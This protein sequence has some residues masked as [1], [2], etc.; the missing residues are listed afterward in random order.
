MKRGHGT[1]DICALRVDGCGE[2][3][4]EQR[5]EPSETCGARRSIHHDRPRP[6]HVDVPRRGSR[7]QEPDRPPGQIEQQK[8]VGELQR[9][10][11]RRCV[12]PSRQHEDLGYPEEIGDTAKKI[13]Q[14]VLIASD[15]VDQ[16]EGPLGRGDRKESMFQ[17]E[18]IGH[19]NRLDV[20][21]RP[22]QRLIDS[23]DR[24]EG[25]D[26]EERE[27]RSQ[28][29]G[30]LCRRSRADGNPSRRDRNR[31]RRGGDRDGRD[32]IPRFRPARLGDQ[33]RPGPRRWRELEWG[34][35][36]RARGARFPRR[37]GE[38][39]GFW[40]TSTLVGGNR[41]HSLSQL[42]DRGNVRPSRRTR[43][44]RSHRR[45]EMDGG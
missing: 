39:R 5:V 33:T 41:F 14:R 3:H 11:P 9:F 43:H 22:T 16:R 23:G 15:D 21:D 8:A 34:S 25:Q 4:T 40:Q 18:Q 26:I 12:E 37:V 2:R 42:L 24:N 35:H 44:R 45:S 10:R 29:S 32:M 19:M 38:V 27:Q 20:V 1:E 28:P 31:E 6:I 30:C 7:V 13:Q 17:G 36:A